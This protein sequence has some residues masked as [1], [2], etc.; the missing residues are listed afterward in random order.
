MDDNDSDSFADE[1]MGLLQ[2]DEAELKIMIQEED[3]IIYLADNGSAIRVLRRILL[4]TF[5]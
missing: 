5:W 4:L 1:S 2:S 3:D